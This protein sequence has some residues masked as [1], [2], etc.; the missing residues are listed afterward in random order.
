MTFSVAP[1]AGRCA[2]SRL[3]GAT[4]F[5]G[6]RVDP[7][8]V[9]CRTYKTPAE[10][11]PALPPRAPHDSC[12]F[13][14]PLG[15]RQTARPSSRDEPGG[16]CEKARREKSDGPR[17]LAAVISLAHSALLDL[18]CNQRCPE[19]RRPYDRAPRQGFLYFFLSASMSVTTG[20]SWPMSSLDY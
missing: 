11:H 12:P 7:Y 10:G 15:K 2:H 8:L 4:M 19:G 5:C 9:V 20:W 16:C 17:A 18:L 14:Y 13:A 3:G 1:T 6:L